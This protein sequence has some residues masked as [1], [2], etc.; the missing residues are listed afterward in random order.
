LKKKKQAEENPARSRAHPVS[1]VAAIV[2]TLRQRAGFTIN[3]LAQRSTVA[4]STISKIEGS[5]LSPGYD[6]ILRLA[7]GLGVD[8]AEMFR[9]QLAAVPTGRRGVTRNGA[10]VFYETPNYSYEALANDVARKE[11]IPLRTTIKAREQLDWDILPAHDGEE[12]VFVMSGQVRLFSEHYEPLDLGPGDSV[13]FDS[14]SGHGLVSLGD[15]DAE[16]LWV[17]SHVDAMTRVKNIDQE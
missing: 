7:Q 10:G 2:R 15:A 11:F 5:L 4:A 6:V 12:F 16:V 9:P 17:C 8:V 13:Y 14:R 1:E 3:E